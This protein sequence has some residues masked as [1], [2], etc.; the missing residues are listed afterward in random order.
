MGGRGLRALGAR[1]CTRAF[2]A[3]GIGSGIICV[4]SNGLRW[5]ETVMPTKASDE[6]GETPTN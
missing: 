5:G 2:A 1:L 4:V 3:M 6:T